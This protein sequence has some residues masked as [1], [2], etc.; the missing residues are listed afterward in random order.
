[1][2]HQSLNEANKTCMRSTMKADRWE[3]W[4]SCWIKWQFSHRQNGSSFRRRNLRIG[5]MGGLKKLLSGDSNVGRENS[6]RVKKQTLAHGS[7]VLKYGWTLCDIFLL[8][9]FLEMHLKNNTK[10]MMCVH[11]SLFALRSFLCIKAVSIFFS[12]ELSKA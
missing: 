8:W 12:T 1:M 7:H 4:T 6:A 3:V 10:L 2:C 11:V 5:E 9:S